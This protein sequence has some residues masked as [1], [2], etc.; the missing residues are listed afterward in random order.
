MI[1]GYYSDLL[2]EEEKKSKF[3]YIHA[4]LGLF[5]LITS[6]ITIFFGFQNVET[7]FLV[8]SFQIYFWAWITLLILII[9]GFELVN[10][11]SFFP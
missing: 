11:I 1:L 10:P 4:G 3:D 6:Q 9:L 5:I 8:S 2:Y 7:I